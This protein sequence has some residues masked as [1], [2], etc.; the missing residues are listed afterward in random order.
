MRNRVA[1]LSAY[2]E[3]GFFQGGKPL[4]TLWLE[5]ELF[6][7]IFELSST[8]PSRELG[9]THFQ[10]RYPKHKNST[11]ADD[12]WSFASSLTVD[13]FYEAASKCFT[14]MLIEL[15]NDPLEAIIDGEAIARELESWLQDNWAELA[16]IPTPQRQTRYIYPFLNNAMELSYFLSTNAHKR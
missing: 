11:A 12:R 1:I 5:G 3:I 2:G 7:T 15:G 9:T 6:G 13:E 16:A 10:V 14:E 8:S 4:W